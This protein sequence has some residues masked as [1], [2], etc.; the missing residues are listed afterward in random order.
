MRVLITGAAGFVGAHLIR[1]L[2]QEM[3]QEVFAWCREAGEA[4]RIALDSNHIGIV[5]I[6]DAK[7]V[8]KGL[9]QV[10]PQ[11]IYHLAA[12]S[13][14]GFSWK[15]PALTYEVNAVGTVHLLEAARR[16]VPDARVLLVGSA[17]QYG[18]VLPDEL[19]VKEERMLEGVNPYSVSK[20]TQE[21]TAQLYVKS[22]GMQLILVRAFN[23]I[24][25]G[26][27][28][29]FVIPDWCWQ[30]VEIERGMREP[31]LWVGNLAVR[32]DFTDVRDIVSA[33]TMLM[34]KGVAGECYNVGSGVSYSLKEVLECI[35]ANSHVEGIRYEVD[36]AKLRPSDV[37]ELRADISKL[38]GITDWEPR[39]SLEQSIRDILEEM[40]S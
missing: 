3:G 18:K 16:C 35:L 7:Q 33:Y 5:D 10:L 29:Q 22:Y 34:E 40:R 36:K 25:T 30:V 37:P 31:V 8:Q 26:Q 20:M 38:T 4:S 28:T 19:P 11:Q 12:Q 14:V 23:H 1:C 6:T 9:E 39:I 15:M 24:G 13:S 17:E 2:Q 21:L 27:G 32:R